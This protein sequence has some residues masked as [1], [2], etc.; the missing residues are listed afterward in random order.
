MNNTSDFELFDD[1]IQSGYSFEK[2]KT[3]YPKY[4]DSLNNYM[5]LIYN[6][7]V[8]IHNKRFLKIK[9]SPQCLE[10]ASKCGF[11]MLMRHAM[12]TIVTSIA[13]ENGVEVG[14]RS[15]FER[16]AVLKGQNIPGYDNSKKAVLSKLL[17]LTNEIAHPH[18]LH[19]NTTT[20]AQLQSFYSDSFK[21]ILETHILYIA[22]IMKKSRTQDFGITKEVSKSRKQAYKYLSVLKNQLDNFNVFNKT[23]NILTQG[24]LVRQLTECTANLWGYNYGI[25]PTDVSTFE[26]QINLGKVLDSLAHISRANRRT[27]FGSSALTSQVVSDLYDLKA[28]SNSIMHVDKFA[29]GNLAKQGSELSKY[30]KVVKSE[31]SPHVMNKKLSEADSL[32]STPRKKVREKSP[33][34]TTL[35]CGMLGW[36][37][38]HHFY[39]GSIAK[40]I[41]YL[42]FGGF[43]IGP[44]LDLLRILKGKF[45]NS[46]GLRMKKTPL[47]SLFAFILLAIHLFVLYSLGTKYIDKDFIEKIK[48]F[49]PAQLITLQKFDNSRLE[50]LELVSVSDCTSSSH[51]ETTKARYDAALCTDGSPYTCWQE[52]VAGNGEG[53]SLTFTFSGK[54]R[55]SA[56]SI[57]NGKQASEKSFYS[58]ARAAKV[59]IKIGNMRYYAELDD[60]MQ[61]QTFGFA[62]AKEAGEISIIIDSAYPGNVWE[63]LCISEIEFYKEKQ[64]ING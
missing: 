8:L 51:L 52:G 16:L 37:G 1:E 41:I 31:C 46:R 33:L 35:L 25:V 34:L 3:D 13:T 2:F 50:N 54:E 60:I 29:T 18:V 26:N 49:D 58:N 48:N 19:T 24:C 30:Y 9:K 61:R 17:D 22:D 15:V 39:M 21:N 62:S 45:R 10:I 43:I 55:I 38:A 53:E 32:S 44:T 20:Y 23:T 11:G 57:L 47:S 28:V 40:G 59:V 63:D 4:L 27:A 36:L 7:Y 64:E 6:A 56:I 12:E 5:K 42:L 14:G